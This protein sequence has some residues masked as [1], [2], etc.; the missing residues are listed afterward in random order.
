MATVRIHRGEA[1]RDLF[2]P[3]CA[4]TGVPTEAAKKKTFA[5]TPGWTKVLILGGLL[6]YV[7]VSMILTK[8]MKVKLPLREGK[9]GHW[10]VRQAFLIVG[11]L[12]AIQLA[13][14]GLF[15]SP[16]YEKFAGIMAIG[17]MLLLLGVLITGL[18]LMNKSIHPL[19]IT[20][21]EM[22]LTGVHPNFKEALEEM[23]EDRRRAREA[24]EELAPPEGTQPIKARRYEGD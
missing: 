16:D 10:L 7:V 20:D 3:I 13:C 19:E 8:R 6:P 12:F 2:P 18:V 22:R 24:R 4:L 21:R 15:L 17:G 9:H 11:G 14:G 23:R 1:E 5:W